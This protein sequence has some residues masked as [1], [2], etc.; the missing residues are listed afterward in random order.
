MNG[1]AFGGCLFLRLKNSKKFKKL[2]TLHL[3]QSV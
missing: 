3:V 2:L 1:A